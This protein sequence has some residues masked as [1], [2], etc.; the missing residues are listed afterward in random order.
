MV[1]EPCL[2]LSL[3]R[4]GKPASKEPSLCLTLV[5]TVMTVLGKHCLL[6][7]L[8]RFRPASKEPLCFTLHY[9]QIKFVHSHFKFALSIQIVLCQFKFILCHFKLALCQVKFIHSHSNWSLVKFKFI[10]SHFKSVMSHFKFSVV[11]IIV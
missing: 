5:V 2:L 8:V 6:L 11:L 10:H 1:C 7:A 4:F 3:F 9:F